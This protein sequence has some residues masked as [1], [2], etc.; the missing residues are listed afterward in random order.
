MHC[1]GLSQKFF[2]VCPTGSLGQPALIEDMTVEVKS[3]APAPAEEEVAAASDGAQT[4]KQQPTLG[5]PSKRRRTSKP[6][7]FLALEVDFARQALDEIAPQGAVGSPQGLQGEEER[8][9]THFFECKLAGYRGWCW[10]VTLS[11]APRSKTPTV[12]ELGLTPAEGALLAP[13]WVPWEDRLLPEDA[14]SEEDFDQD[15]E[16]QGAET[17][18]PEADEGKEV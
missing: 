8:L 4:P 18:E 2:L 1:W 10:F 5:Q 14:Q 11:R 16:D 15:L 7:K 9:T 13:A 6:D 3:Q 12:C 17:S